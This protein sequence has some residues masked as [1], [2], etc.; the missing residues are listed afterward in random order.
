MMMVMMMVMMIMVMK[1]VMLVMLPVMTMLMMMIRNGGDGCG[2]DVGDADG[3]DN[4]DG[5]D[6]DDDDNE[7]SSKILVH[8]SRTRAISKQRTSTW[9]GGP[10]IDSY[11]R[12]ILEWGFAVLSL[13]ILLLPLLLRRLNFYA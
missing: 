6:G 11:S 4:D 10:P 1:L 2:D 13:L 12:G 7:A 3:D 8:I 9:G 5:D